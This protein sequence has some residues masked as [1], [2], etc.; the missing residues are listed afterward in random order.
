MLLDHVKLSVVLV[1]TTFA[2]NC[3]VDP[4]SI[5]VLGAV[6]VND[7]ILVSTPIVHV[8]VFPFAVVAVI[9]VQQMYKME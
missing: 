9:V 3:I 7:V 8:A 4:V 1:G 6:N 2:V 5:V